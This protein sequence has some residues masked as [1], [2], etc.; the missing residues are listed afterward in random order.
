MEKLSTPNTCLSCPNHT[1][2]NS[3]YKL[4]PITIDGIPYFYCTTKT[5]KIHP[6]TPAW[7]RINCPKNTPKKP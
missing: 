1:T 6:A 3:G 2:Q 7:M 4:S 5:G